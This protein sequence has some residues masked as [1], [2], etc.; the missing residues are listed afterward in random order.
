MRD[1]AL[2]GYFCRA[3]ARVWTAATGPRSRKN[4]NGAHVYRFSKLYDFVASRCYAVFG[5]TAN[6]SKNKN[7]NTV[8]CRY[9]YEEAPFGGGLL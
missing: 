2:V 1:V 7:K 4:R 8:F 3:R 6:S 9:C 5:A